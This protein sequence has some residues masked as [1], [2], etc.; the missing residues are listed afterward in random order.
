MRD[1]LS[2]P[3]VMTFSATDP[4]G[5]AGLQADVLTLASMYCHPISVSTA[6]SIQ[7]TKGVESLI[8]LDSQQV[9]E[10]ALIALNDID[11]AVFKI[12]L[13]GS[14][15]NIKTVSD[16]LSLYPDTPVIID[17]IITSGRGDILMNDVMKQEMIN[18]L[19]PKA[20]LITPNSIEAKKLVCKENENIQ[21]LSIQ[22]TVR[23]LFNLG[24]QNILITGGH[25]QTKSVINT[26]YMNDGDI[27][28]FETER[29]F[30]QYHGSGCT[31]SAAVAGFCA[32][33]YPLREAVY[34]AVSFTSLA[35]KN[36]FKIGN[37]QLI[38][39]RFHWIFNNSSYEEDDNDKPTHH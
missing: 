23:R 25:E 15:D 35:L 8:A 9:K 24:C 18:L 28:P 14:V 16:I 32:Q 22:E 19:F 38:P 2:P 39:D 17:P 34:E 10:Q 29:F 6:I 20:T 3:K 21:D 1:T 33:E 37:G 30:G 36:A 27:V 5:G 12:G 13:L 7:D 31:L 4:T 11:V 26:L